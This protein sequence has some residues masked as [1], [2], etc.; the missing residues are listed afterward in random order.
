MIPKQQLEL[1]RQQI[2]LVFSKKV[3]RSNDQLAFERKHPSLFEREYALLTKSVTSTKTGAVLWQLVKAYLEAYGRST[4]HPNLIRCR[5]SDQL[6]VALVKQST[7]VDDP[8]LFETLSKL[9]LGKGERE[10]N[11]FWKRYEA[12]AP[13]PKHELDA[14]FKAERNQREVQR[15]LL[16]ILRDEYRRVNK[17]APTLAELQAF[18]PRP[19]GKGSF[20]NRYMTVSRRWSEFIE[21]PK[22]ERL[23]TFSE[24]LEAFSDYLVQLGKKDVL[25]L[26]QAAKWLQ[27]PPGE[28]LSG[29]R[30][31]LFHGLYA[32]ACIRLHGAALVSTNYQRNLRGFTDE[33]TEYFA[34]SIRRSRFLYRSNIVRALSGPL[35]DPNPSLGALSGMLSTYLL[36]K[37]RMPDLTLAPLDQEIDIQLRWSLIDALTKQIE[38]A[39]EK[40]DQKMLEAVMTTPAN[41]LAVEF[42]SE[43]SKQRIELT[44]GQDLG[45]RVLKPGSDLGSFGALGAVKVVFINLREGKVFVEF[46]ALK[47]HLFHAP[48]HWVANKQYGQKLSEI[49]EATIGMVHLTQLM[50]MAMGFMPVL[51]HAGFAGLMYEIAATYLT[52]KLEEQLAKVVDPRIAMIL[53]LALNLFAPR[54]RFSPKLKVDAED[55]AQLTSNRALT[56]PPITPQNRST[57]DALARDETGLGQVLNFKPNRAVQEEGS[58]ANRA[59]DELSDAEL[60]AFVEPLEVWDVAYQTGQKRLNVSIG[61]SPSS[62]KRA[63][64]QALKPDSMIPPEWRSVLARS[65]P[66]RKLINR[67]LKSRNGW[68]R[69]V[70]IGKK[71]A[72]SLPYKYQRSTMGSSFELWVKIDGKVYKLD[73]VI[74][75]PDG[76]WWIGE[77]KMSFIDR[78]ETAEG[79]QMASFHPQKAPPGGKAPLTSFDTWH[80]NKLDEVMKNFAE[81][82]QLASENGFAG[83]AVMTNTNFLWQT[84]QQVALK[85]DNVEIFLA[86]TFGIKATK[87]TSKATSAGAKATSAR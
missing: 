43:L 27:L 44:S 60:K 87:A 47:P 73:G 77:S 58:L 25:A 21:G 57:V 9:V 52:G 51:I 5:R 53:G 7:K 12:L 72:K 31:V 55:A 71:Q 41:A 15:S 79:E 65:G 8:S 45:Y 84:F 20:E 75:H 28:S 14:L 37:G 30:H 33:E 2:E 24:A 19:L 23:S 22:D 56:E 32:I 4:A 69:L 42:L 83:V 6:Y 81:R 64:K 36:A 3:E 82:S 40:D 38:V 29:D 61:L 48:H 16:D 59:A 1:F 74:E 46:D 54:P 13:A 85:M 76:S 34:G 66:V 39:L 63:F 11:S 70:E 18:D 35:Y 86:E 49:H 17:K 50:F 67:A 10:L 78:L 62:I 68:A 26:F 80:Y